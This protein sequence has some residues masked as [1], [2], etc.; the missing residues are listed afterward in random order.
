MLEKQLNQSEL[1]AEIAEVAGAPTGA[2][3][4]RV[5]AEF[6]RRLTQKQL[7]DLAKR[8]AVS[9]YSRLNKEALAARIWAEV[10]L[11]LNGGVGIR[12][13]GQTVQRV[14]EISDSSQSDGLESRKGQGQ[15]QGVVA[16]VLDGNGS[17]PVIPISSPTTSPPVMARTTTTDSPAVPPPVAA[18]G[19]SVPV[20]SRF[21][22]NHHTPVYSL[23]IQPA[24]APRAIP[25]GYAKDRVTAMPVDPERLYVYWEVL[26]ESIAR[27]RHQLDQSGAAGQDAWLNVRLYDTTG[28]IFDGS[29][30]HGTID[31]GVDRSARQWF[32]DIGRP[33]S[34][35]IAEIGLLSRQGTFVKIARS[36]RVEF[37]RR[38]PV[39][40]SEPEWMTVRVSTG[41]VERANARSQVKSTGSAVPGSHPPA[42]GM[43]PISNWNWSAKPIEW[44]DV[45]RFALGM[46]P[47]H[48]VEW[49]EV[50]SAGTIAFHRRISWESPTM[51]TSW[52]SGPLTY[53]VEVPL[54]VRES[55][56]GKTRIFKVADKTHVVYG[57]WQVIIRGLGAHQSRTILSR[58]EVFRAWQTVSQ[59]EVQEFAVS[60][61][62]PAAAAGAAL[63]VGAS[64]RLL[65]GASELSF[66]GGSALRLLGGSEVFLLGASELRLGGASEL[67]FAAA[68]EIMFMGASERRFAGSSE[69][70]FA[71]GSELRLGLGSEG[72]LMGGAGGS[73]GRLAAGG[74]PTATA[75]PG[76]ASPVLVPGAYPA[77]PESTAPPFP[78]SASS[79]SSRN[80]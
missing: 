54:P 23:P 42:G 16:N 10:E 72:R 70:R 20:T 12:E 24:E 28:R 74:V 63:G 56:V 29:N 9:G 43:E 18:P 79:Q 35:L 15:G 3:S 31:Q 8:L 47:E 68:S 34:E 64:E 45:G 19:R 32:F 5:D 52:E 66:A 51:I 1:L 60:G 48:R 49:E 7:H 76:L 26:E 80:G 75:I 39:A 78:S 2:P 50:Q 22:S 67:L 33:T 58:W 4:P 41:H 40:W 11:T 73:E 21:D 69:L 62:G 77:P 36:G 71:G 25:W 59:R 53:P 27:A 55:F 38:E 44:Q 57:P 13:K 30:A 65:R 14:Q 6:L 46:G 17:H 37:P 61:V